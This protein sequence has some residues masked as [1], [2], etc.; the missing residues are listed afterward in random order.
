MILVHFKALARKT[1]LSVVLFT[2]LVH[3]LPLLP[4]LFKNVGLSL[5]R[6][7]DVHP[8]LILIVSRCGPLLVLAA[9]LLL[10]LG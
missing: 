6:Q 4:S 8:I 7:L 1:L 3:V 9:F 5:A 10:V 2:L